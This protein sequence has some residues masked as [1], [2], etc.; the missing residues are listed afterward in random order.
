VHFVTSNFNN[1]HT[2]KIWKALKNVYIDEDYNNFYVKLNNK[3]IL[4][5]Y[6]TFHI[7]IYLDINNT[8]KNLALLEEIFIRKSNN[9]CRH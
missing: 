5:H 8:K 7:L 3:Y 4:N 6:K 9:L 1:L 2:D